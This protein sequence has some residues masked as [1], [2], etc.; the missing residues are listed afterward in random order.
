LV[1]STEIVTYTNYCRKVVKP[2]IYNTMIR[3]NKPE[4]SSKKSQY[5]QALDHGHMD[6]VQYCPPLKGSSADS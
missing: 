2:Y 4:I 1:N 3:F 6:R 5:I